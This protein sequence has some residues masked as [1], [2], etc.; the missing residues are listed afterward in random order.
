MNAVNV[1]PVGG[2]REREYGSNM[3]SWRSGLFVRIGVGVGVLVVLGVAPAT[4]QAYPPVTLAPLDPAARVTVVAACPGTP[5]QLTHDQFNT[6]A[7]TQDQLLPTLGAV[8]TY[9]KPQLGPSQG[10]RAI[11]EDLANPSTEFGTIGMGGPWNKRVVYIEVTGTAQDRQRHANALTKVVPRPDRVVVCPTALGEARRA[12]ITNAL[13]ARFR[14]GAVTDPRFYGTQGFT[15]TDGR[16]AVQLRSDATALATELQATYGT[17]IMITL[18][19]F[20]WSNPANPGPG[21]DLAE[22]CGNVP[23][24]KSPRVDWSLP[25]GVAVRSGETFDL[26]IKVRNPAKQSIEFTHLKAVI[27]ARGSR[28]IVAN[29]AQI[30]SYTANMMF[31][32]PGEWT[33]LRISGGTDSCDAAAGWALRPGRYQIVLT[34]PFPTT[35]GQFTS[36]AIS[37][38]VR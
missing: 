22:R 21:S 31:L 37:L 13:Y 15:P 18:G 7:A 29:R 17:D 12:E 20:S 24:N 5:G 25:K 2:R 36:P 34:T 27:A 10:T 33:T 8:Q 4:P 9:A 14:T 1:R 3:S 26:T 30:V 38:T 6:M 32:Q 35:A 19:N 11:A 28:R 16:V 23:A